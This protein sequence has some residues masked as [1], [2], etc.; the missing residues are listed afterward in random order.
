MDKS[1]PNG[2]TRPAASPAVQ[3]TPGAHAIV[4]KVKYMKEMWAGENGKPQNCYGKIVDQ[5]NQPVVGA[6][7]TGTLM[8]IQGMDSAE[9]METHTTLSDSNGEFQF[10]GFN[11]WQLGV[12]VT[13]DGYIM[14]QG[15]GVYKAPNAKNESSPTQ[16]AIF[17][18][19]K[20]KGAEPLI[21]AEIDGDIACDGSPVGYDL[22]T[23]KVKREG[24]DLIVRLRRNPVNIVRSKH[25]DWTLTFEIS[26]GG[27]VEQFDAY[28]YM[29]PEDGYQTALVVNMPAGMQSWTSHITPSY[30]FKCR[31][32]QIYGSIVFNIHA[33]FQPPPTPINARIFANSA[34]SRNLEIDHSKVIRPR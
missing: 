9:K 4:D 25:F 13:K 21:R 26:D 17:K 20:L 12:A 34:G 23:G 24:G 3:G 33:D 27:L 16:R 30:Y 18:M 29:A 32:G 14:G 6:T 1:A 22:L 11:A 8:W 2:L 7:A 31:G 28:P 19:W 5:D 10:V 15:S